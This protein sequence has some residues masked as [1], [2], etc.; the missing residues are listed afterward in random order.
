ML[1]RRPKLL[2]LCVA[3]AIACARSPEPTS[4]PFVPPS[5][6]AARVYSAVFD[7][8]VRS[9]SDVPVV[10]AESTVVFRAPAGEPVTWQ[11]YGKVPAGLPASLEAVSQRP[12]SSA[13]LPLPRPMRVLTRA[14]FEQ[15]RLAQPQDWWAE[16]ARRY[17]AQREVLAFSPIAFSS[18]S[19]TAMVEF[20]HGCGDTC[21]GGQLVWL[22][23][24]PGE[25]W[26]IRRTYPLWYN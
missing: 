4:T 26:S 10:V 22:E 1:Q 11:E 25:R 18:D 15:I 6:T 23:R 3:L 12:Q 7:S 21:G 5:G 24:G 13:R 2:V 20:V 8:L 9:A 17:P 19:A 14:E 16:F